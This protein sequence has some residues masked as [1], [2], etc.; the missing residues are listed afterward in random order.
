MPDDGPYLVHL[1]GGP[2][3]LA[4]ST[5]YVHDPWPR[6][7]YISIKEG[8][9]Y[10]KFDIR[11]GGP[12]YYADYIAPGQFEDPG[13]E[14]SEGAAGTTGP[15]GETGPMGPQ[16]AQGD[17]GASMH[18]EGD[19]AAGI[20]YDAFAVVQRDHSAYAS[21]GDFNLGQDP[22]AHPENWGLIIDGIVGPQGPVGPQGVQ[23][24]QG[25]A[26]SPLPGRAELT[27]T[28]ATLATAAGESGDVTL[29]LGYRIMRIDTTRAAR[30]RFYTTPA[31]RSA[32]I[33]RTATDD[34]EGDHGCVVE[35]LTTAELL[36]LDTSPV[37]QGYSMEDPPSAD[38]AWRVDNLGAAGPVGVTLLWQP[39]ET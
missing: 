36:G 17:P 16:G 14:V 38:I 21:L 23:G 34:P 25:P 12:P 28:T 15:Q 22:L 6:S 35:V 4:A 18:W 30:V 29:A 11:A 26:G 1:L 2:T 7:G 10:Y 8:A 5:T 9:S 3:D 19:W 37:P 31:K 27:F 13:S 24:V 20:T 33:L 32:D 39:Q